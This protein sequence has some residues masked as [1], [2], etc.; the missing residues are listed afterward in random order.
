MHTVMEKRL[1]R[2]TKPCF[3]RIICENKIVYYNVRQEE[4]PFSESSTLDSLD[5]EQKDDTKRTI[6]TMLEDT[7]K[8]GPSAKYIEEIRRL[9]TSH[10][11]LFSYVGFFRYTCESQATLG[12]TFLYCKTNTS[13]SS[14]YSQEQHKFL[15]HFFSLLVKVR[16]AY[17]N[18]LASCT[19]APLL[20]TK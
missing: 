15:A 18:L 9:A 7:S 13:S 2:S 11:E 5:F 12:R 19:C 1:W 14:N 4:D 16:P 10:T 6:T 20:V 3:L 17:F 8:N